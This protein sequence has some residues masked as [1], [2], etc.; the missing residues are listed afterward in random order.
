MRNFIKVIGDDA[1]Y[2][3]P[4]QIA[5]IKEIKGE[6]FVTLSNGEHY[7]ISSKDAL[8]LTRQRLTKKEIEDDYKDNIVYVMQKFNEITGKNFSVSHPAKEY[9]NKIIAQLKDGYTPEELIEVVA[10]KF[11]E[12]GDVKE[13][14]KYVNP[15][16]LFSGKFSAYLEESRDESQQRVPGLPEIF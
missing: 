2:I 15:K 14:A 1:D 7:E 3:N 9:K 5:S 8:S 13:M 4:E 16:T 12:W 10:Y 6:Y 11:K